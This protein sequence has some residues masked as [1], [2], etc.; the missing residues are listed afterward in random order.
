MKGDLLTPSAVAALHG[1]TRDG[2]LKA[3][4]R[5]DLRARK[6]VDHKG[7][8]ISYAIEKTDADRWAPRDYK[9]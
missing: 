6:V 2:V 7:K 9:K 3:I 8:V 4:A 5:G 1:C